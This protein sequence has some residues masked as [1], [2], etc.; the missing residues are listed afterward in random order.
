M[1]GYRVAFAIACSVAAAHEARAD[2][3][4]ERFSSS[5]ASL[6]TYVGTG[7]F[8]RGEFSDN[9]YF[10]E[11]LALEPRFRLAPHLSA[12]ALLNVEC[13]LSEPDNPS[14]RRCAMSDV[15]L[16]A[17]H[18]E[19]WRDPWLDG[20]LHGSLA[21]YLPTSQESRFNHTIVNVRA[22]AGY[23]VRFFDGG[24]ELGW[25]FALQKYLPSQ[26]TRGLDTADGGGAIP[27]VLTRA[28]ATEDGAAGSGGRMN[29]NW[30]VLDTVHA[31]INP[32]ERLSITVQ[33]AVYN[34]F[35]FEVP[36]Q[37][38][39]PDLPR[40]GRADFTAG[41]VEAAYAI[42]DNLSLALGVTSL[43]PALTADG[44]SLRFP[45]YDFVSPNNNYTRWYATATIAL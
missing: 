34:Y 26:T 38:A 40:R 13:E 15:R 5:S 17:H 43:Q 8:V 9:P 20:D 25:D 39:S 4:L 12:R 45:F 19:L 18:G 1:H 24:L 11:E 7:T 3:L 27:V 23:A 37:F 31:T 21:F 10:S 35:R 2:E 30:L 22:T 32:L 41:V 29:D 16:S 28:S 44:T 33:L 6:S 14:A 36:E 42:H